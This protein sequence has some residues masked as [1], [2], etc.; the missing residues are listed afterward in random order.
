M[1]TF[2]QLLK[3]DQ[4]LLVRVQMGMLLTAIGVSLAIFAIL[5]CLDV[6]KLL[7]D[8]GFN[9]LAVSVFFVTL[10]FVGVLYFV[11]TFPD[12]KIYKSA[13]CFSV[14]LTLIPALK[15]ASG[16]FEVAPP[17]SPPRSCPGC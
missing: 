12:T 17:T 7:V 16:S 8:A 2:R 1:N 11:C 14:L 15:Q 3:A 9:G 4:T 5:A 13:C 6:G 10:I